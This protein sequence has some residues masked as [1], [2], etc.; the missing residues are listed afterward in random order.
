MTKEQVKQIN[1]I[2]QGIEYA[3]SVLDLLENDGVMLYYKGSDV[4]LRGKIKDE[5]IKATRRGIKTME[6]DLRD[7]QVQFAR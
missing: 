7:I 3:Q 6:G 4:V 1:Q 2:S 5:F